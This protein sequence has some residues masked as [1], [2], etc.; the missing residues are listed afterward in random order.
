[1][2]L[3]CR[4]SLCLPSTERLFRTRTYTASF[5]RALAEC[6]RSS[7]SSGSSSVA[8]VLL[9]EPTAREEEL[10]VQ[11]L[12]AAPIEDYCCRCVAC[13]CVCACARA[14][15]CAC[16]RVCAKKCFSR[17][18]GRMPE[19]LLCCNICV[20]TPACSSRPIGR[21]IGDVS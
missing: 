7:S 16:A 18:T 14:C 8:D 6:Y 13:V 2:P 10:A 17:T 15:A 9:A 19:C 3:G 21:T 12:F 4:L 20:L 1:M 11:L 5:A